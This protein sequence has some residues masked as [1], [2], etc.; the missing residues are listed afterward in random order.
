MSKR[1][2]L[3]G[4]VAV[5]VVSALLAV[6]LLRGG[7]GSTHALPNTVEMGIDPEVT[8]NTASTLG[9]LEYCVRVDVESPAF[10]GV[11]DYDIDVYVQGDTQAPDAYDAYVTYDATKVHIT[12][13]DTNTLVKLPGAAGFSDALPDTDGK[14]V[15]GAT[16][17]S[18]GP[19]IAGDGTLVRLGLDIGG[20]GVVT[21]DFDPYPPSTAYA[22][23]GGEHPITRWP[24]QLAINEDCPPGERPQPSPTPEEEDVWPL[25]PY[26]DKP[27]QVAGRYRW[28]NVSIE[29][30][31][32]GD[33]YVG[34]D[35]DYPS[36]YTNPGQGPGT[37][38]PVI[39]LLRD[40]N[41]GGGQ[42][43]ID[44]NTGDVVLE[45]LSPGDRA[46]FDAILATVRLEGTDAP[47]DVWPYSEKAPPGPRREFQMDQDTT[48]VYY[49]P[50]TAAGVIFTPLWG[51]LDGGGSIWQL[52]VTSARSVRRVDAAG[53]IVLDEQGQPFGRLDP[54]D[55][56]AFGRFL[57]S[58][59]F[60]A[61]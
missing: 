50:D 25:T 42:I 49:Q 14:F 13:P 37:S 59:E 27:V 15:A 22:S 51:D 31:E 18:G 11:S 21:F 28:G 34:R 4:L 9:T 41:D 5:V 36:M 58:I 30:P 24:A 54:A 40:E 19:G 45:H 2:F 32:G 56:E 20:S 29:R 39:K 12:A 55:A 8:G 6:W 44:A 46:D 57:S 52:Q 10:D 33:I 1:L 35:F 43:W 48:V 60:K 61:R 3:G 38:I 23:T 16:Y 26:P 47:T 17:L 53:K 7:D